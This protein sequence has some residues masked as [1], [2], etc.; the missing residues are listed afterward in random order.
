M[1]SSGEYRMAY[2]LGVIIFGYLFFMFYA[3]IIIAPAALVCWLI[4][5][6]KPFGAIAFLLV[7]YLSGL[8]AHAA[9]LNYASGSFTFLGAIV[10]SGE[11]IKSHL[12]TAP[13]LNRI[14]IFFKRKRD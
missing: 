12:I 7:L 8:R 14:L 1:N 3:L 4:P 10:E 13:W 9:S 11:Q 5:F 2:G 6:L